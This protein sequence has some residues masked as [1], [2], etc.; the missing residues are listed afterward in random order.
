MK[1]KEGILKKKAK[2]KLLL[3]VRDSQWYKYLSSHQNPKEAKKQ[4]V[5]I[6][7]ML[8]EKGCWPRSIHSAKL[9]FRNEGEIK[10]PDKQ[11]ESLADVQYKKH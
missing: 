9:Y 6:F 1:D 7:R 2:D 11:N 8:K 4:W 3:H 5:D 10:F